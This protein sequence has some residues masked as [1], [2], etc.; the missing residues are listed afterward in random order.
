MTTTITGFTFTGF[1]AI[2]FGLAFFIP[3]AMFGPIS[4]VMNPAIFIAQV[5]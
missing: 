4:A 3:I 2:G 1:I 5:R